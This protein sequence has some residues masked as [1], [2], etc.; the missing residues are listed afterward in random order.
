M[1]IGFSNTEAIEV[2]GKNSVDGPGWTERQSSIGV[3]ERENR[4][5][6]VLL[7]IEYRNGLI[8]IR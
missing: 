5:I 1:I 7:Y 3:S 2:F 8:V 4:K 6:I